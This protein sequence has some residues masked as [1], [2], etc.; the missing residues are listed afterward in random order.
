MD[1]SDV[2]SFEPQTRGYATP[3]AP[4][5]KDISTGKDRLQAYSRANI[6]ENGILEED[7]G[8]ENGCEETYTK[9]TFG[10]SQNVR[11]YA[12]DATTPGAICASGKLNPDLG[13]PYC[14]NNKDC[15]TEIDRYDGRCEAATKIEKVYNWPGVCLEYDKSS[16]LIDDSGG[17]YNCNQWYPVQK[18]QGTN[19]LFDNYAEAGYYNPSGQDAMF[20]AVSEPYEIPEDR[21]YC[22]GLWDDNYCTLLIKVPAGTEVNVNRM[23]DYGNTIVNG[24]LRGNFTEFASTTDPTGTFPDGFG[25]DWI[26][27]NNA[28]GT[29]E[30]PNG[31]QCHTASLGAGLPSFFSLGDFREDPFGS[32]INVINY[33]DIETVFD[34][35]GVPDRNIEF[36]YYDQKVKMDGT[37][38][39]RAG[40]KTPNYSLS[41]SDS[42]Y[43]KYMG[44]TCPDDEQPCNTV[45]NCGEVDGPDGTYQTHEA[46]FKQRYRRPK[47]SGFLGS[48]P[49]RHKKYKVCNPLPYNYY[50]KID[51]DAGDTQ[52]VCGATSCVQPGKG[53][54]CLVS[55]PTWNRMFTER[56]DT[57]GG[58]DY[59]SWASTTIDDTGHPDYPGCLEDLICDAACEQCLIDYPDWPEEA[60]LSEVDTC[61][62]RPSYTV[63]GMT[64]EG[65][66][67]YCYNNPM[68]KF[69]YCVAEQADDLSDN[70]Y[71][72]E[73]G[74][75]IFD[76]VNGDDDD[77]ENDEQVA[78]SIEGCLQHI[79]EIDGSENG[80]KFIDPQAD[81]DVI[82]GAQGAMMGLFGSPYDIIDYDTWLNIAYNDDDSNAGCLENTDDSSHGTPACT[83]IP[84]YADENYC[85]FNWLDAPP[86]DGVPVGFPDG[87]YYAIDCDMPSDSVPGTA[88]DGLECFQQCGIISQLDDMGDLSWLRTDIWWRNS[89]DN[90]NR[91]FDSWVSY[92]YDNNPVREYIGANNNVVMGGILPSYATFDQTPEA[93]GAGLGTVGDQVVVTRVPIEG[94]A[95]PVPQAATF[96]DYDNN[97]NGPVDD[98]LAGDAAASMSYLFYSVYNLDWNELT[99]IYEHAPGL[100]GPIYDFDINKE[101]TFAGEDYPPQILQ[102]CDGDNFCRNTSTPII[103]D[104]G[105]TLNNLNEPAD[106]IYGDYS[107]FTALKF[108]YHAHPDH[109]PITNIEI[110]WGDSNAG[111]EENEGRYKNSME[112]CDPEDYYLET[113]D[114]NGPRDEYSPEGGSLQG[115]GGTAQACREGYKVFYHDYIYDNAETYECDGT[116]DKPSIAHAACYRPSVRITDRWGQ[117]STETFNSWVVIYRE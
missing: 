26:R 112:D 87:T 56:T 38:S 3:D 95:V 82:D 46:R 29:E 94:A 57:P 72:E 2:S 116:G 24:Y 93:Y 101:N 67:N 20:C 12:L 9:V 30:N 49:R 51:S 63:A 77:P 50:I 99:Q 89:Q 16:S 48:G 79:Y 103:I 28:V 110:D 25:V 78:S 65:T 35:Y 32:E 96:F 111:W 34:A 80:Y 114:P 100:S 81:P 45:N 62:H 43:W 13:L 117:P 61:V 54:L 33:N 8:I 71:C 52:T 90:M 17:T 91:I 108:F 115:F 41:L 1:D 104:N 66:D 36:Y 23:K 97:G 15:D 7:A 75:I 58:T 5:P 84:F 107:L 44:Y 37:T 4:F 22:A 85:V 74:R 83:E 106:Y 59:Y 39:W 47:C 21:I 6:C 69:M 86:P 40:I 14:E 19:S 70:Q 31:R 68:C 11:Y 10:N 18:I 64:A 53:Q 42:H 76:L 98:W 105:V 113:T 27:N 60:C 88:C 73:Y 92:Y 55:N 102:V 109:M